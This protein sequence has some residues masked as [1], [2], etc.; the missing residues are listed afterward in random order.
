MSFP[1]PVSNYILLSG[2][3]ACK[4]GNSFYKKRNRMTI[5][6]RIDS[7]FEAK[8][9]LQIIS[10]ALRRILWEIKI[11]ED[12][13]FPTYRS[14]MSLTSC[15]SFANSGKSVTLISR[16]SSPTFVSRT[17]DFMV[18]VAKSDS[19]LAMPHAKGSMSWMVGL[20]QHLL[21]GAKVPIDCTSM[22]K[23]A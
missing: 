16:S 8:N 6:L 23:L 17:T 21:R 12:R 15:L 18:T 4:T 3:T 20:S 10:A 13:F 1:A 2:N 11:A 7:H 5:R 19:K 22:E 9:Q 14:V